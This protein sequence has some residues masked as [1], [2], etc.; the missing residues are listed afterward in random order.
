MKLF[1]KDILARRRPLSVGFVTAGLMLGASGLPGSAAPSVG[2]STFANAPLY[3]EAGQSGGPAQF[4]ARG[5]ACSVLLAPTEAEIILG[6]PAERPALREANVTRSVRLQLVGANSAS[7]ISGRDPMS[8]RANYFIGNERAQWKIGVPLFSRVQVDD[9]YPGVRMVYYANES[10]QLEYDFLLQPGAQPGQIGFRVTGADQVRVDEAG[11]LALK[12]GASEIRQHQPVAYQEIGGARREIPASYRLNRD[13]TIGFALAEYDRS[14]PLVIDPVLDFLTYMGGRKLDIG[15]AIALDGSGN[16]YV[17]GETLSMGLPTTNVIQFGT[18]DFSKFRGGN[19]AFGDAFVAKYDNSGALQFLTYLGG[20]NDDGAL[21]IAFDTNNAAVWVTGFTDSTNFPLQNPL[22]A[23]LAGPTKNAKQVPTP[24]AFM[25]KLDPSGTNLLYSTFFGG[26]NIDEGMGIT[27]DGDGGVYA[28]GITS[29]TNLPGLL[30]NSF[31]TKL[32][33]RFDAFITKL[34]PIGE[35]I[36]TNAYTTYLGGTNNE[37]GLSIAVDSGEH[38][39]VT[40]VTFSTNFFTTNAI[41][42]TNAFFPD[43]HAFTD[44]NT[45]AIAKKHNGAFN[46]DAF[47]TEISADGT[48]APFS[49]YLGG[50]NDDVGEHIAVDGSD[51]IYVTGLTFSREF[52]T[53]RITATPAPDVTNQVVFPNPGTNFISHVFVTEIA[54]QALA[55]SVQ[56]GGNRVDSGFGIAVDNSGLTYVTGSTSSTNFFQMP[57]LVTNSVPGKHDPSATNY[58]GILTNSPVFADVS[59]TNVPIKLKHQGN[60]NDVFIVVLSPEFTNFVHTIRLAGPGQDNPNG[61][62]VDPSGSAIY[63]VGSTTSKTNFATTNAAQVLFSG[64]KNGGQHRADAFVGKI[65]ISP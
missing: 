17:A 14:L 29:S 32:G 31:Q 20:R 3:F 61:I 5:T 54:N 23:A 16:I 26:E 60:T 63:I 7:K 25:V 22:D 58:F 13:G 40:G 8:A 30:P 28:T 50:T 19:N 4:I 65:L 56:F 52:P 43:G 21:G 15:W 35:N 9:A 46:S 59:N 41:Q 11:N 36:Y 33:G 49:T 44:L 27:V 48:S 12:I 42:L 55:Y 2:L 1:L 18:T 37:Y 24:D 34:I 57:L 39:W 62:A 10:A 51:N 38:A 6:Q 47:V 64:Q 53:N 45:E